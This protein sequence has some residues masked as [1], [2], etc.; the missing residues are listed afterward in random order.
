MLGGMLES[1][2]LRMIRIEKIELIQST[3]FI[4]PS[5][6]PSLHEIVGTMV[7]ANNG[8]NGWAARNVA[9]IP[10]DLTPAVFEYI[11]V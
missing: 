11:S 6:P 9:Y 10:V 4:I 1:K 5:F 2:W 8:D 3:Y 7:E